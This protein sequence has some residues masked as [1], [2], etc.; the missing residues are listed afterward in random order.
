MQFLLSILRKFYPNLN[1]D[2]IYKCLQFDTKNKI[3]GCEIYVNFRDEDETAY[4]SRFV[5]VCPA[6]HWK[7][8]FHAP[9]LEDYLQYNNDYLKMLEYYSQISERLGY[10]GKVNFHPVTLTPQFDIKACIDA[11]KSELYKIC[12]IIEKKNMNIIP[13]VENLDKF[14]GLRRCGLK[15]LDEILDIDILKF[16]WDIGHDV[17]E[18]EC[19]YE[20]NDKF[21]G[22]LENVHLSD[23][24]KEEHAP[25]YYGKTN[26]DKCF[27][28]FKKVNFDKTIVVEVALDFL[29]AKDFDGK[30]EEYV[31]NVYFLWDKSI[32]ST[33]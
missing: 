15:D 7:F 5:E 14:N 16:T 4:V 21:A 9:E 1:N 3:A 30:I 24:D 22:K 33:W 29:K 12:N 25:F 19:T 18:G 26:L 28:Y 8:Q 11:S 32:N 10:K 23:I 6:K 17:V 27:E 31:K 13:C 20:L 2:W